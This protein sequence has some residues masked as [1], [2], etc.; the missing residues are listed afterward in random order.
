MKTE[1]VFPPPYAL[2]EIDVDSG[3]A[4]VD[5]PSHKTVEVFLA[6]R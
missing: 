2:I 5:T 3:V 6:N 1:V 4:V